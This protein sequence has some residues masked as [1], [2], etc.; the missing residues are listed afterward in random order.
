MCVFVGVRF[1]PMQAVW[2]VCVCGCEVRTN[3]GSVVLRESWRAF[4]GEAS[5]SVD[6]QELA[7]VL[8]GLT[9]IQVC[10]TR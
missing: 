5:D 8:L 7:V 4:A 2:C 6:T 3:A 9:F 10:D 1:V